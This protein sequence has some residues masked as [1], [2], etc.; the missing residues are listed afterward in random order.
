MINSKWKYS[1]LIEITETI[2][3]CEKEWDKLV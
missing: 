2:L 1:N 3:F